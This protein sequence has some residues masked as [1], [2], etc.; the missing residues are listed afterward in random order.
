MTP[1]L[2]SIIMNL[3]QLISTKQ[4][5]QLVYISVFTD[6]AYSLTFNVLLITL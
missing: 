6:N 2:K 5:Q 1:L 3:E 4:V